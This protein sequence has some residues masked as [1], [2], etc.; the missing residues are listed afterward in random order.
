MPLIFIS[1]L[2]AI[3]KTW[4]QPRCPSIDEWIKKMYICAVDYYSSIKKNEIMPFGTRWM[5]LEIVMLSKVSQKEKD[6]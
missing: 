5:Q 4:R 6:K 3:A 1:A 2:F